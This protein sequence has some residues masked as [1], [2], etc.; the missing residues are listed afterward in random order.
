MGGQ[1]WWAFAQA[2]AYRY[3]L[4]FG[5]AAGYYIS[6]VL[7]VFAIDVLSSVCVTKAYHAD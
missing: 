4:S 6:H 3:L 2:E 5:A 1:G 7:E